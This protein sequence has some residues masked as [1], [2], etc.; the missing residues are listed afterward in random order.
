MDEGA[1]LERLELLARGLPRFPDG[2]IDYSDA[3]VAAVVTVFVRLGERILLLKR[4]DKVGSYRGKWNTVAGYL[5]ELK[6]PRLKALEE[7]REELGI[8]EDD[9]ASIKAGDPYEFTDA[10]LGRTWLV[11]PFL[12][13]LKGEPEITLCWEHTEYKWIRPEELGGFDVVP[14]L[15]KSLERALL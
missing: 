4:S 6:P 12:V 9:I 15:E 2:R 7:L 14:R 10:T 3:K 1:L 5:D 8:T 11:N 13:D